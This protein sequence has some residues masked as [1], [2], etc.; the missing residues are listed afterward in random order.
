MWLWTATGCTDTSAVSYDGALF[1]LWS[2]AS[3]HMSAEERKRA[4]CPVGVRKIR[5][6]DFLVSHIQCNQCVIFPGISP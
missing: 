2:G 3:H 1:S 5:C 6:V 4:Y